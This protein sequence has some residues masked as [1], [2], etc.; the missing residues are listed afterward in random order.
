[1]KRWRVA[2]LGLGHWYSAYGL[3]RALPGYPHAEL[4]AA[5][6]HDREQLDAFTKTFGVPGYADARELL[7][8]EEVDIVQIAAPVAAIPDLAIAAAQAG[9][10][11]VLGKPMAMTVAQADRMVDAVDRAGVMCLPFQCIM[12]LRMGEAKRRVDAG[13]IGDVLVMHQTSRWSIAED[14]YRSG[15]PGWFVDPAQVP[16]G[17]FIDEGIY[18]I[19]FF[20][21][22]AASDVIQVEAK[23]ANLVH[24]DIAVED[25]GM[26]TFTF[27]NGMIA[28]LEAAWTIN[29]PR[30]SGPSPKQNSVVRLEIVGRHG[31][32]AEQWFRAPGRALLAAGAENWVFELQGEAPFAPSSPFPLNHLIDCLEGRATPVA[33]IHDARRA[34]VVAMAAYESAR[35]GQA[36]RLT[37][38]GEYARTTQ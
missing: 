26:A 12:R 29:A 30:A 13:T 16:G 7:A 21:W 36:V 33:T 5:A 20:Q 18:W 19:D 6:W 35:T 37:P 9:K 32:L 23:M 38:E 31:E 2:V 8:R 11:I 27:A 15:K 4:V 25:W 24:T 3:A 14:A 34:F 10:H 22:M 28:T 17:A 1:M